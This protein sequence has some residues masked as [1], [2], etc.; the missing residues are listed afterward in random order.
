MKHLFYAALATLILAGCGAINPPS[1]P[2]PP[3]PGPT[4]QPPS[5]T[6]SAL[7]YPAPN[8]T[9][10][11]DTFGEIIIGST[12]ALPSSWDVVLKTTATP[13]GV[14]GGTVQISAVPFPTPYATPS[15]SN[16]VYQSSSFAGV[17][18][19]SAETV[20]VYLNDTGSTCSPVGPLGSFMTQ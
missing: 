19:Q 10:I 20:S 12:A 13:T 5:G 9:G 7:V 14:A 6:T 2:S 11:S 3:T 17:P 8:S 1:P 16:P 15:F 4:C 18:F